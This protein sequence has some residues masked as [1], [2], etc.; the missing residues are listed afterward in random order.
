[1]LKLA[2]W[3]AFLVLFVLVPSLQVLHV[4]LQITAR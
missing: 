1:M 2:F 4:A 3:F